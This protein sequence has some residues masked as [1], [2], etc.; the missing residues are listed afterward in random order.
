MKYKYEKKKPSRTSYILLLL[1]GALIG[2]GVSFIFLGTQQAPTQVVQNEACNFSKPEIASAQINLPAV[3]QNGNGVVTPL[4]VQAMPGNGKVLA[5]IEKLLFWTD[6]Q[7]SIQTANQV[8][9]DITGLNLSNYDLTYTVE[10]D[11]VLIG[12]PSAGGA[13]AIATIAVLGNKKL[14]TDVMMTGTINPDGTIGEVGGIL[15][16]AT[17][18]KE[19][20][21]KTFLVPKGQSTETHYSPQEDCVTRGR[22]QYCTTVY[23]ETTVNISEQV[24]I[25]VI[26]VGSVREAMKYFSV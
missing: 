11:S 5:N 12:G 17:A 7:Q 20:G 4:I 24:G 13:L 18:A 15:E 21:V 14:Q 3:D 16:K 22:F 1:A 25:D 10:S 23:N 2:L 26:E 19:V 9:S 6:T 8:A